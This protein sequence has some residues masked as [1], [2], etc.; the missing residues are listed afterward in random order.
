MNLGPCWD[1]CS[2][3]SIVKRAGAFNISSASNSCCTHAYALS[4]AGA[5][6]MLAS[7]RVSPLTPGREARRFAIPILLRV[8]KKG[9]SQIREPNPLH[10]S[11]NP[12]RHL[13]AIRQPPCRVEQHLSR[14]KPSSTLPNWSSARTKTAQPAARPHAA[15]CSS[16]HPA[17]PLPSPQP[18]SQPSFLRRIAGARLP[19]QGTPASLFAASRSLQRAS[20]PAARTQEQA[21]RHRCDRRW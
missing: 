21:S 16:V 2:T 5:R 6:S 19:V 14:S 10:V 8:Y 1:F 12:P 20:H 4:L 15:S 17:S 11:I 9:R 7:L 13:R 18:S 3:I